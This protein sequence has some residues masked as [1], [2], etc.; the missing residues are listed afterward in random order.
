MTG[1]VSLMIGG[2]FRVCISIIGAMQNKKKSGKCS[3]IFRIC[4]GRVL[5]T[6]RTSGAPYKCPD[7]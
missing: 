7:L 5:F 3:D 6:G 1:Q 2:F 4:S